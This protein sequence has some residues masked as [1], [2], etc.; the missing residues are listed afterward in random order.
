MKEEEKIRFKHLS[1]FVKVAI[2]V[3]WF[4]LIIYVISFIY[5]FFSALG[6]A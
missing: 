6:G 5:G 2:I 4:N 3:S 1:T